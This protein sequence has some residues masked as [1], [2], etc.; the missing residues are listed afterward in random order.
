MYIDTPNI[1]TEE[2]FEACGPGDCATL[3]AYIGYIGFDELPS[4]T[5][6]YVRIGDTTAH[7]DNWWGHPDTIEAL[8]DIADD[9]YDEF[10]AATWFDPD[11]EWVP[12]Y[13]DISVGLTTSP[14]DQGGGIF[15]L[16]LNWVAG[17]TGHQTHQTGYQVDIRLSD[18]HENYIHPD[19]K[20]EFKNIVSDYGGTT[21]E[22]GSGCG[23]HYHVS[24]Q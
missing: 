10:N 20:S 23:L 21:Q 19:A 8:E 3:H 4:N 14:W 2:W 16:D 9:Y 12:A 24:F 6:R 13:N 17:G 22:H 5:S 11:S 18:C 7:P 15:D 1:I